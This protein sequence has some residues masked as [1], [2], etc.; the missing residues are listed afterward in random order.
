M[1]KRIYRAIIYRLSWIVCRFLPIKKDKIVV[2]S[3]YG[4]GYGDNPK[5][6]VEE[7]LRVNNSKLEI[8]WLVKKGQ[9]SGEIPVGVKAVCNNSFKA[10]FHLST[11]KVWID[12]CRKAFLFKRKKQYYLQTWHGFALKRIE[13]DVRE[14]LDAGYVKNAIKDSKHIDLLVSDSSFMTKIYKDCFWYNGK[15]VEWGQARNDILHNYDFN[16][17]NKVKKHFELCK[18]QKIILYAPTFRADYSVEPYQIDYERLIKNC[19]ERFG[20]DFVALVRLHP[21][22]IDK[23]GA[24]KFE[25]GKIINA[26]LYP[27]MQELLVAADIVISDYSSL[28]FDF[29]LTRKPCFQ[30]AVDIEEYKEDRNFYFPLD[31]LPFALAENNDQLQDI[32]LNFKEKEYHEKLKDF[33]SETG[34]VMDGQASKR[35]VDWILQKINKE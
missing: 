23:C 1:L 31:Q 10:I 15:I 4:R 21:N 30:F 6:I 14:H 35:C 11:A 9:E 25:E 17:S 2:S 32:I 24:L 16:V 22:I 3:Y 13:K 27:D 28:M 12:N 19:Q 8:I 7:L 20:G 18:N 34:M 33:F 29:A 26:S 5:Y